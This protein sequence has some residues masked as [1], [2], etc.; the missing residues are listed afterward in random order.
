MQ[1]KHFEIG[2]SDFAI[3]IFMQLPQLAVMSLS[4]NS[5]NIYLFCGK[6]QLL[7]CKLPEINAILITPQ[8]AEHTQRQTDR[9]T[10]RQAERKR[11]TDTSRLCPGDYRR[12]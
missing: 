11:E 4:L 7:P 6:Q 1:W 5:I 9:Q 10:N 12:A 8:Q 3:N 2:L